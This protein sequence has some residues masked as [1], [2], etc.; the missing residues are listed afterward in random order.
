MSTS[1]PTNSPWW[2]DGLARGLFGIGVLLA[3][4]FTVVHLAG[5]RPHTSVLSGSVPEVA[6]SREQ[7]ILFGVGYTA[8]YF[9]FVLGTPICVLAA[10]FYLTAKRCLAHR[11]SR[12]D[13]V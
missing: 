4:A 11:R 13:A 5:L 1:Q 3:I 2:R 9:G 7:A 6:A 12:S 10:M 8:C